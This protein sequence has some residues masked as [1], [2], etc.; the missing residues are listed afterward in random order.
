MIENF[1]INSKEIDKIKKISKQEKDF[2]ID[3][4]NLFNKKGFPDKKQEDWKFSDLREIVYKNFKKLNVN[5]ASSKV[6][7]VNLIK[8]FEH[9]Y[10]T[11]VNGELKSSNFKFEEKNKIRIKNF[12]NDNFFQE[13]K[14]N[15]LI[16]LNHALSINGY[17]VEIEDNYKFKKTLVI[18]NLFTKDLKENIL[19]SR[20]KIKIGKN[21]E[22]HTIDLV[23]NDSKYK[24]IN[25]VYESIILENNAVYKN[26]CIQNNKSE[27]YFHK[28]SKNKLSSKSKYSSFIFPSGS[29]FNK[30][31]LE[32]NLEGEDS[33]CILQS[34]SFLN[35]SD[36]QEIK[37][38]MNHVAPNCKSYQKVKNVLSSD[39][40][41]VYQGKIYVKDIAQK[42]NAYQLSKALLLSDNSEFNSKP[43]L[44]IYAD[45][46]KCSHGATSGSV[47]E[48]SIYYLMTRGL[49]RKESIK[50][51][52]D[53]FLNEVVNMI[54]SNSVKEFV[55]SKLQGQIHGY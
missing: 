31:D 33:E 39:G 36:H 3:N 26:I 53:G 15:P 7:K 12:K 44:E 8:D 27:G 13:N 35:K 40:K 19:N 47:D 49:S 2:R 20:N 16:Y 55:K 51:L 29:K 11:I 14:D 46:V 50:L 22:L 30:L 9:N 6:K 23:V 24:F 10:I 43:E 28:F 34:A 52:I 21:S 37:T 4:L 18:Y 17:H 41:G 1:K 32:F 42:T 5:K 48:D 25:N 54:K 45:D 38:K